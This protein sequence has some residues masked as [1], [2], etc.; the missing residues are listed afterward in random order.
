MNQYR[1]FSKYDRVIIDTGP[2]LSVLFGLYEHRKKLDDI[3]DYDYKMEIDDFVL[4]KNFLMNFLEKS[5]VFITPEVL[6]EISNLS[7]TKMKEF[8][9][10]FICFS[11]IKLL[12]ELK[13]AYINKDIIL[14]N[15]KLLKYG[16]TDISLIEAT[17]N[18]KGSLLLTSDRALYGYCIKNKIPAVTIEELRGPL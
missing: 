17:K 11:K 18:N 16:F 5:G 9:Y 12:Q 6:A 3:N 14:S 1:D 10:D 13:E 4:V 8:F 15:D 7:K 2:L